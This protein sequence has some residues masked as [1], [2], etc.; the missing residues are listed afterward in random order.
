MNIS[1][2]LTFML[3]LALFVSTQ[4]YAYDFVVNG[5]YYGFDTNTQSAYVTSGDNPYS[6]TINIPE[7]VTYNGRS[8]N[9]TAIG[10]KAFYNCK[11][12]YSVHIPQSVS[13]INFGAFE[14]CTSLTEVNLPNAITEVIGGTFKDCSSLTS[15]VLPDNITCIGK[16]AFDGCTK[17][18]SINIPQNVT[19]IRSEAFKDCSSLKII[20]IPGSVK[21]LYDYAFRNCTGLKTIVLEDSKIYLG[22]GQA[23]YDRNN[24]FWGTSP[25]F[26]YVGRNTI[27][28]LFYGNGLSEGINFSDLTTLSIGP[29][30]TK[31][32]ITNVQL[33]TSLKTIYSLSSEPESV[34]IYFGTNTY[35]NTKLYVPTGTRERYLTADGWK[36]FF[37][38][39]EMD[40]DKMWDGHGEP[41]SEGHNK[42]KCEKPIISYANGK[43][44]FSS[45][46][47]NAICQSTITDADIAS[48]SGNEV[49]LTA[50]YTISVYATA[51]DYDNSD[52]ATATLCWLN[53]EPKTEGMANDIAA[54]RGNAIMIQSRGGSLNL[55]G[56]TDGTIVSVYS[57]AGVKVGSARAIGETASIPTSLCS[58]EIAIIRIGDKSVKV[59]MQ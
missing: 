18:K 32:T 28:N 43:L 40:I 20:I 33:W 46:T 8:L 53:A 21:K 24:A 50:T 45:S 52:V 26:I 36:N 47:P 59:V 13:S 34:Q 37:V 19:E 14:G 1:I 41:N 27:D 55:S 42:E 4:N 56:V 15:I 5:I 22:D 17:L 51:T 9:V 57:I 25:S 11:E 38:I 2:K 49:S 3:V 16:N 58:G 39:E 48:F 6:G 7:S 12:L 54:V 31:L 35:A 44:S 10:Y 23:L 30:V 29:S